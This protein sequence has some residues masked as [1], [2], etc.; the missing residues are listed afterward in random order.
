MLADLTAIIDHLFPEGEKPDPLA[1]EA[2]L[3][4]AFA[5]SRAGV[6]IGGEQYFAKIEA[7]LKGS[8]QP[9]VLIG[10]VSYTHL[11]AHET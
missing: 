11:R 4:E 7:H 1:Q 10:A 2:M 3:H 6:Y 8:N 9:L 5:Q